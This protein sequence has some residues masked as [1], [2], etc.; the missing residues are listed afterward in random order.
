MGQDYA[1]A[2]AAHFEGK[3][4]TDGRSS[5]GQSPP[6]ALPF[7]RRKRRNKYRH[8]D[9]GLRRGSDDACGPPVPDR[10]KILRF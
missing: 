6:E 4:R 10:D 3:V 7:G 2:A 5:V 9:D 8:I 1:A